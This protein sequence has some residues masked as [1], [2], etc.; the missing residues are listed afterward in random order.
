MCL[1]YI[2]NLLIQNWQMLYILFIVAL[3][4]LIFFS[5]ILLNQDDYQGGTDTFDF[6]CPFIPVKLI[7]QV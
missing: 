1:L 6:Q 3:G 7:Q 4:I 5:L 2:D